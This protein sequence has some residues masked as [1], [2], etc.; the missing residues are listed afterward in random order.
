MALTRRTGRFSDI[1]VSIDLECRRLAANIS[2]SEVDEALNARVEQV[3]N[4]MG[5]SP[6]AALAYAPDD[7]ALQ[8][9]AQ[10]I[11]QHLQTQSGDMVDLRARRRRPSQP[12]RDRDD[13]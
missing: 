9:A 1:A 11:A 13:Q 5:L 4:L 3:G 7:L 6:R 12:T 2:A 10:L 8:L